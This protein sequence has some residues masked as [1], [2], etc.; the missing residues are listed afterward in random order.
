LSPAPI[1][2]LAAAA[3]APPICTDRPTRANAVCT[4]PD[5]K[6]QLETAAVDWLRIEQGSSETETLLLGSSLLKYG[7]SSSSDLQV[8][9]TPYVRN[10]VDGDRQTGIGDVSVRFK[11]R[12]TGVDS[13]VQAA[14]IPFVKLPAAKRGIGNGKV[15]G[16]VALPVSFALVGRVA[17]AFGPEADLVADA[18]GHGRHL[19]VVQLI[20]LSAPVAPRL[21]LIGELW[22][23]WNFD[24]AGTV[25]QASADAALAYAVSPTLQFDAGVNVGLT[26]DTADI[27]ISAGLAARF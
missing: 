18:D 12:L 25:K 27:E 6:W 8:G 7:I 2:L 10:S 3:A 11:Q 16:G 1:L 22:A 23:N 13:P 24:P 5:G 20:N 17:A 14:V 26:D 21:A 15:E 4:V 19:A 9:F